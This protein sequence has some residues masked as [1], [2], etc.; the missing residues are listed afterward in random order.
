VILRLALVASIAVAMAACRPETT[1]APT[2]AGGLAWRPLHS[3][4]GRE[5]MQ[6][7]SFMSD[8]GG[9]R[10][11][12]ETKNETRPGAGLFTLTLHS[13]ISGRPLAS[14]VEHRGVGH[15]V[16]FVYEDPRVFYFVVSAA[17]VE[18]SFSADEGVA[19]SAP[20]STSR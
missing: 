4:S 16:A 17:N 20:P 5:S 9:F 15:D 10:V 12:W 1:R 6:T 18:W 3:W 7:E 11:R 13:A 8:T 19:A 14:V 2:G